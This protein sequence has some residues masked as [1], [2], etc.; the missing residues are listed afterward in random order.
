MSDSSFALKL[1]NYIERLERLEEE[2]SAIQE[3]IKQVLLNA[4]NDGF[5]SKIIKKILKIR[6]MDDQERLEEEHMIHTYCKA[7]GI[8]PSSDDGDAG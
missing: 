8:L 2:K 4:K 3:D 1:K 6:K 5:D 7:I